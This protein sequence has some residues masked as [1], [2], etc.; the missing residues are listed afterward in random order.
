MNFN[1]EGHD[2]M[3]SHKKGSIEAASVEE[4]VGLL[5]DKGIFVIDLQMGDTP[6][7][8]V[9]EGVCH[10]LGVAAGPKAGD[11]KWIDP[12]PL[13]EEPGH[14]ANLDAYVATVEPIGPEPEFFLPGTPKAEGKAPERELAPMVVPDEMVREF[15]LGRIMAINRVHRVFSQLAPSQLDL[16]PGLQTLLMDAREQLAPK[17]MIAKM[18]QDAAELAMPAN[19]ASVQRR[20]VYGAGKPVTR[21]GDD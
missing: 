5:R 7:R 3:A 13:V 20:V 17:A 4:A 1:Y 10:S 9:M 11:L 19:E 2:K 18:L 14:V 21:R 6:V 12:D 15:L 8:G 16:E